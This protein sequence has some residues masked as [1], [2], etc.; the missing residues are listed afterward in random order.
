M[1][2]AARVRVNRHEQVRSLPVRALGA[3]AELERVVAVAREDGLCAE[4]FSQM[5]RQTLRHG[6]R[7]ELL[8]DVA[9]RSRIPPAVTRI[10]DDARAREV[11]LRSCGGGL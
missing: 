2:I 8:D 11:P 7:D 10:D 3:I 9:L 1:A 4:P 5:V 6:E